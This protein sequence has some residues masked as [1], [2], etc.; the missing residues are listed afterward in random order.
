MKKEKQ[1]S[2][3]KLKLYIKVGMEKKLAIRFKEKLTIQ[4]SVFKI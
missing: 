1:T 4:T 2:K 3:T